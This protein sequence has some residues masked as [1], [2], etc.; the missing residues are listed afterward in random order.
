M[1]LPT[2]SSELTETDRTAERAPERGDPVN[3]VTPGRTG[4][5]RLVRL[6]SLGFSVA[7]VL[8]LGAGAAWFFVGA[9]P[10]DRAE[11]LRIE[12]PSQSFGD[13]P[14]G[15]PATLTFGVTNRSGRPIKVVGATRT[16]CPHGCLAAENL[17]LEIPLRGVG[18]L[19]VRVETGTP[20]QFAGELTIFSDSPGQP[21]IPLGVMGLVTEACAKP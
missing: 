14:S 13:V 16:C 12:P 4:V 17:P 11:N 2:Q 1:I 20:G 19:V 7:A 6:A 8:L 18:Q 15:T 5:L 21:P 9:A 3:D 10:N